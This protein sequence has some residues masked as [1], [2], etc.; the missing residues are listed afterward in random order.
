MYGSSRNQGRFMKNVRFDVVYNITH[1]LQEIIIS[2][3]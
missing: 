1:E 2:K 3:C